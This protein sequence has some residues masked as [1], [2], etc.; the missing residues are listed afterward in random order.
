MAR[1]RQPWLSPLVHLDSR[2]VCEILGTDQVALEQGF[3]KCCQGALEVG[4]TS[5]LS[6][7]PFLVGRYWPSSSL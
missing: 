6:D 3:F 5:R 4:M 2:Y 7:T 1:E